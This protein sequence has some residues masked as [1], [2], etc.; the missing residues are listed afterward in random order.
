MTDL[1]ALVSRFADRLRHE[2]LP[3]GP[4]RSARF[5]AA[6]DLAG[7]ATTRELYWCG[8]AT[9]VGDH[10]EIP[11]FDRVFGLVFGGDANPASSP[12]QAVPGPS[13]TTRPPSV[14]G[15]RAPSPSAASTSELSTSELST[16]KLSTSELSTSDGLDEPE[17][18]SPFPALAAAQE[19][20]GGRDFGT[21]SPDE[22]RQLLA[23]M[24]RFRLATPLRSSRRYEA[25]RRGR[26]I[27]L[28]TTLRQAQRTGGFPVRLARHR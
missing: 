15:A 2:G 7:P 22:L 21:L 8:L 16:S 18:E 28:R 14:S 4:E 5:A 26:R 24:R 27:D 3:V 11:T 20:L 23:V 9:L 10:A 17:L 13:T 19:R 12:G 25:G 6:V 1:P